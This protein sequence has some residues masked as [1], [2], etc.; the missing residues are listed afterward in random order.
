MT[1]SYTMQSTKLP[2]AICDNIDKLNRQFI[3]G[4]SNDKHK[5]HLVKW[6]VVTNPR[7]KDGGL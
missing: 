4:G 7:K 2:L 1:S 5:I 6:D 3:W